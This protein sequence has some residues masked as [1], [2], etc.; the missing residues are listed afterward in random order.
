[1]R[2]V[3]RYNVTINSPALH[4]M[5]SLSAMRLLAATPDSNTSNMRQ[6]LSHALFSSY[7][8]ENKGTIEFQPA[9]NKI[10]PPPLKK[11]RQI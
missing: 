1:M 9:K 10:P 3:H 7:W 6:E 4:P 5:N 2:M 8:I 11:E